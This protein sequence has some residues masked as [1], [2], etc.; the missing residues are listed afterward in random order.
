MVRRSAEVGTL[1]AEAATAPIDGHR[2]QPRRSQC[3]CIDSSEVA[4]PMGP[5]ARRCRATSSS[6]GAAP[7]GGERRIS[8]SGP[9]GVSV[10]HRGLAGGARRASSYAATGGALSSAPRVPG[11][12]GP[13][14]G[15]TGRGTER[16][17][18]PLP[19]WR[20]HA[21][22]APA[23]PPRERPGPRRLR[24]RPTWLFADGR[25][26]APSVPLL[27]RLLLREGAAIPSTC[28]SAGAEECLAGDALDATARRGPA[29]AT[30]TRR[31]ATWRRSSAAW[32]R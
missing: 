10:A 12:R 28:Y 3:R 21:R 2:D 16:A 25:A 7:A 1:A 24:Q 13:V 15:S 23:Q 27:R 18:V 14:R 20:W 30:R 17:R 32:C 19:T 26:A 8:R 11:G 31:S 4:A 5:S 29:P 22:R 9:A 6:L